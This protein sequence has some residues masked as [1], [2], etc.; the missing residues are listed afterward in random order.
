M[1]VDISSKPSTKDRF[2]MLR[3]VDFSDT[4]WKMEVLS[5]R[6]RVK[7]FDSSPERAK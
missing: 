7:N 4:Y 6:E 1:I 3:Y 5:W 2:E